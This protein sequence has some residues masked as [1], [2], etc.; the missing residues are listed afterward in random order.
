MIEVLK[1]TVNIA[2][3]TLHIT[4]YVELNEHDEIE[5]KIGCGPVVDVKTIAKLAIQKI[6]MSNK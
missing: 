5:Y 4:V 6:I 3:K 2:S 1:D